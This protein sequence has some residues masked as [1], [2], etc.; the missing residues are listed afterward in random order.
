MGAERRG[1]HAE[2]LAGA[3]AASVVA[4]S[5]GTRPYVEGV[6]C[7]HEVACSH[8]GAFRAVVADRVDQAR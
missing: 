3:Q 4:D 2:A 1:V 5:V 7:I 6:A 8:E